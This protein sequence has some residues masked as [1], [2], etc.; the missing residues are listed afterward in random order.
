MIYLRKL[1]ENSPFHF[2]PV[3][4][5]NRIYIK[6]N[7][8]S[9]TSGQGDINISSCICIC[10]KGL[11]GLNT[12][13]SCFFLPFLQGR[14]LPICFPAHQLPFDKE[15]RRE[16]HFR[17]DSPSDGMQ[18]QIFAK[19]DICLPWKTIHS[20]WNGRMFKL[21]LLCMCYCTLII[22]SRLQLSIHWTA[23]SLYKAGLLSQLRM[24]LLLVQ[25]I[26]KAMCK[27]ILIPEINYN[28]SNS[29]QN[30]HFK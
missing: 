14:Q 11:K 19:W 26:T 12:L 28:Y 9:F 25:S 29:T 2:M 4:D 15:R 18:K 10:L 5:S 1:N 3:R 7:I 16:M 24:N 17:E 30:I 23:H 20:P 27:F 6:T 13:C 21:N 8:S 22:L